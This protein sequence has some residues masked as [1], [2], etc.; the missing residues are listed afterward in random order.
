MADFHPILR[1]GASPQGNNLY[2]SSVTVTGREKPKTLK[3]KA[4]QKAKPPKVKEILHN[5]SG[6]AESGKLLAVMGSTGAGKTTLLNVLTQRNLSTLHVSGSIFVDGQRANKY[7]IREMSAFVQQHDM[8][9]GTLT[10]REHLRFMA[11]LRMGSSYTSWEREARIEEVIKKMGLSTCAETMIGIPNTLKG[12]S[13]GEQKRLA[14]ASEILTCPSILFCD[15]PT[16]GLDAFMAGHV[17]SALRSLA[18]GGMTIIITIHQPST[19]VYSMFNNVCLMACGRII[20]LGAAE[21]A[22]SLFASVGFKC[23][24]YFNP[25][26]HLIRT[27]AVI[28]NDKKNSIKNIAAIRE[29]FLKTEAGRTMMEISKA[30]RLG[31]ES[32]A[33]KSIGFAATF[34]SQRYAASFWTQ[35]V[36]LFKRA[37][38][39]ILRNPLIFKIRVI[40]TIVTALITGMVYFATPVNTTTVI[41]INGIL[42]NHIRNLNF[43]L[44]FPAVPEITEELPLLYRE[45]GNGIYRTSAYFIAKNLAELPQYVF[46]PF[47]YIAIVYWMS[48]LVPLIPQFLMACFVCVLLTQVAISI[49]YATAC[50][51]GDTAVAMTFLP[52]F[53]VPIMAFGGFFITFDAIPAYFKWLSALSY[54]KYAY[55]ALAVN[56]WT[57]I[58][59]IPGTCGNGTWVSCPHTGREVLKSID[60]SENMMWPDVFIMIA[61]VILLRVIAY[62]ALLMRTNRQQ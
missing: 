53:V 28:D 50:I 17:V 40:Q 11:M 32:E 5:V 27:L 22:S 42:F 46:L 24:D 47:L 10:V 55:E 18:E 12:L 21:Q 43:M 8:F 3:D 15:E 60:F 49:S 56:E 34:N 45:N 1:S 31:L 30:D 37:F 7:R 38:I 2:W 26:D 39:N 19:Q 23:P 54:F 14:F 41:T 33:T 44:Q 20:Y 36:A 57:A 62:G 35:M 52:I 16:S 51:F 58:D 4:I 25:A 29:A 59:D 61:M 9:V 13:C 6:M 48:G